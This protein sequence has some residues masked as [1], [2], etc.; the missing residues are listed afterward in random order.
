MQITKQ[1]KNKQN[2]NN[3]YITTLA[4]GEIKAREGGGGWKDGGVGGSLIC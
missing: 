4:E 1:N 2:N 3:K